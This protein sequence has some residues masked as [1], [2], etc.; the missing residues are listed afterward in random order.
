MIGNLYLLE[1]LIIISKGE[2]KID[3]QRTYNK[4]LVITFKK[5][6]EI[7]GGLSN[8]AAGYPIKINGH[9]IKTSEALYQALRYTNHPNYQKYIINQNSPMTAKMISKKYL[10]FTREDWDNVRISIMRWCLRV[11]LFQN[12]DVF[13]SLL[14]ST[15]PKDIVELS[16]KDRFWGAIPIDNTN[17]IVGINALGRLLMELRNEIPDLVG[18]KELLPPKI[19]NFNLM[20]EE[21]KSLYFFN[22]D[23]PNKI[24]G[25][26]KQESLF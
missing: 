15:A 19:D 1:L 21:I 16:H 5:T 23:L 14:L 20:G 2:G 3:I 11:K 26:S 17:S 13:G 18:H 6:K 8:M 9:S 7:Y 24:Q 10:E 25:N 12:W 4:E 22:A